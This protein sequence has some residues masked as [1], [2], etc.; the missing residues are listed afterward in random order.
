MR[1]DGPESVHGCRTRVASGDPADLIVRREKL[2]DQLAGLDSVPSNQQRAVE[3]AA[4]LSQEEIQ[5]RTGLSSRQ[6]RKRIE[7]ACRRLSSYFPRK[8]SPLTQP[9]PSDPTVRI[10]PANE[11][12]SD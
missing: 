12:V 10:S 3:R 7:K 2:A 8:N 6:Y 1:Y 9:S 5:K 4:G 11:W